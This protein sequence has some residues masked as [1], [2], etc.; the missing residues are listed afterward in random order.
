MARVFQYM[1]VIVLY[2][3]NSDGERREGVGKSLNALCA[4]FL[5]ISR[6]HLRYDEHGKICSRRI[7][8]SH[9]N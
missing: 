2:E 9:S 6:T 3:H 5:F 1:D 7:S 4:F 8:F